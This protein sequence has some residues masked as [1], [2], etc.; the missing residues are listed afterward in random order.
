MR[1]GN[2]STN[3]CRGVS[4]PAWVS[5]G[6]S[7]PACI[8]VLDTPLKVLATPGLVAGGFWR[9]Q[10]GGY[11]GPCTLRPILCTSHPAP[12]TLRGEWSTARVRP[13]AS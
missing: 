13:E 5:T 9:C 11:V 4:P 7:T 2:T 12:C 8:Q 6:V 1:A 10:V 3:T